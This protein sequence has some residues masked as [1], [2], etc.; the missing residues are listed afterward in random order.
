MSLDSYTWAEKELDR[1]CGVLKRNMV[2]YG[3]DFPSACAAN[4]RYRIKKNDDWTNGFWTGM[5]WMAYLHTGDGCYKDLAM[6]NVRSFGRRLKEHYVLDHHDIG[7]LY[8]P[9]VAAAW[10]VTGCRE[11]EAM[12]AGAADVLAGRFQEKGGFIQAWGKMGEEK[13]YRLIIDSLLNLPLLYTA[14]QITGRDHYREIAG[15]HFR[16][17]VRCIVREDG[18]TYH[19]FYFDKTT[20]EPAYGATHQ[21]FCDKSCWARGQ[22]W[23]IYGIPLH[24]RVSGTALS[25][26]E[27]KTYTRVVEYFEEHLPAD[28]MPYWDL[29]FTDKDSQ[30]KD[31]SALAIAACGMLETGNTTRAEEMLKTCRDMA[32]S[33]TEPESEGLLLHG[34][35]AYGEGKGVDEPNLWGDF[36]YMEGLLRLLRR[37][38][39]PFL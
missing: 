35:Y 16:N 30:P 9:S 19:T 27:A 29:I 7:F 15:I 8:S 32:S 13:E 28:G 22:A 37:D 1:I 14:A 39:V 33:E 17:V 12:I 2:R 31:S 4:G 21:G 6:E 24:A 10:K 23:A 5:L 25:E 38:W 36:F 3:T 34:V 26:A 11:L 18:S 20:G